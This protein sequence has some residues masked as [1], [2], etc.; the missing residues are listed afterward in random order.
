MK[1]PQQPKGDADP[2]SG[3][4]N[5]GHVVQWSERNCGRCQKGFDEA[6]NKF[7]C[8]MLATIN[9]NLIGES[10]DPMPA[11]IRARLGT[12]D[13]GYADPTCP[14]F[15]IRPELDLGGAAGDGA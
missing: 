6:A 10:D 2:A 5:W 15:K 12:S 4:R 11:D 8:P 14:E 13:N 3:F 7:T 9:A 1:P